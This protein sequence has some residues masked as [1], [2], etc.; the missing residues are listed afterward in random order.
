MKILVIAD[1]EEKSLWDYY[2][3]SRLSGVEMIISCGDLAPEYL[4]FLVS[5]TTCPLFYVRGNHDGRY[6][7][8]PPEGLNQCRR[9]DH[10]GSRPAD[11]RAGRVH[12]IQTERTGHVQ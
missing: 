10:R 1:E 3:P 12:A 9:T 6:D 2:D 4:E 11:T 7:T 8:R 5:M